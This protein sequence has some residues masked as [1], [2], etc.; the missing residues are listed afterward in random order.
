[1][2]LESLVPPRTSRQALLAGAA[3]GIL[4]GLAPAPFS[5]L[6]LLLGVGALLLWFPVAGLG[7]LIASRASLDSFAPEASYVRA[8]LINPAAALGIAL[9]ALAALFVALKLR[10]GA[11][12]EWGGTP[13]AL[14]TGWLFVSGFGIVVGFLEYG[15]VGLSGGL[16][17]IVR[18]AS[19]LAIYL[20]AVNLAR[21][22]R[23]NRRLAGWIFL[24]A[25]VPASLGFYQL[26]TGDTGH[27]VYGI[28][29]IAGTFV[30]PNPFGL[31]LA[32]L[33]MAGIG[34]FRDLTGARAGRLWIALLLAGAGVLL[35]FT[36][37]R[38]A[39]GVLAAALFFWSL[40][41]SRRRRLLV[42]LGGG[43]SAAALLPFLAWRFQDLFVQTDPNNAT[44]NSFLWRL[45]NFRMLWGTFLDHPVAGTGLKTMILA[46]PNRS[47]SAEGYTIG[48]AS[49]N[50]ALR[51]LVEQGAIGFLAYVAFAAAFLTVLLRLARNQRPPEQGGHPGLGQALFSLTASLFLLSAVGT[52]FFS[53]TVVMVTIFTLTGVLYAGRSQAGPVAE[54]T[55]DR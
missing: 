52:E 9:V 41:G 8:W 18:L 4:A 15:A 16:R 26:L 47:T 6:V 49:H 5:L 13:A 30:H 46:N 51:V 2:N 48:F 31:Y 17:E 40:T 3:V 27:N 33:I 23:G 45:M 21:P 37:S 19:L 34:F 43:V 36:Y 28:R 24:G 1:M 22:P 42:L 50:E 12:I 25:L 20:L 55:H 11:A 54:A 38:S 10:D 14:W 32:A 44:T 29:R 39:L 35:V 53:E 7:L